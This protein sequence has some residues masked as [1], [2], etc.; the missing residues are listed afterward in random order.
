MKYSYP[1]GSNSDFGGS[2]ILPSDKVQMATSS[3]VKNSLQI[4]SSASIPSGSIPTGQPQT[5]VRV[6]SPDEMN[7]GSQI[8]VLLGSSS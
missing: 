8:S 2:A 5:S 7:R 6:L 1:I 3:S 4:N